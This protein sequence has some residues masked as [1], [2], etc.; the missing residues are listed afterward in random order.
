LTQ[1]TCVT[2]TLSEAVPPIASGVAVTLWVGLTVG[3]VIDT[4]GLVVS[5][6]V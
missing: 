6:G 2:P 4:V 3:V 1:V 5:D